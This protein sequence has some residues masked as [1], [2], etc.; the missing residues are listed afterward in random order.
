MGLISGAQMLLKR[1]LPGI[2]EFGESIHG[3]GEVRLRRSPRLPQR[4]AVAQKG[5]DVTLEIG[6]FPLEGAV[7]AEQRIALIDEAAIDF[8][9]CARLSFGERHEPGLAE[10]LDLPLQRRDFVLKVAVVVFQEVDLTLGG[11]QPGG[12]RV[13]IG[14]SLRREIHLHIPESNQTR[15]AEMKV[16]HRLAIDPRKI[17][18][19]EVVQPVVVMHEDQ[20]RVML[21]HAAFGKLDGVVRV[22]SDRDARPSE[23]VDLGNW[24]IG[25]S[26]AKERHGSVGR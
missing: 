15:C 4:I 14:W 18:R 25:E 7:F 1:F 23:D 13:E 19:F 17:G 6:C 10:D 8:G 9:R 24:R 26:E 11:R 12:A 5:V 16:D 3:T 20:F 21:R 2:R 22:A